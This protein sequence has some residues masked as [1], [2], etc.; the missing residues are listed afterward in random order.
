MKTTSNKKMIAFFGVFLVV[1]FTFGFIASNSVQTN[2]QT[3][4][5][6]T[7]VIDAGHGGP[8]GGSVGKNGTIES[9]LNL[10]YAKTLANYLTGFGIDVIQTRN[11]EN[12]LTDPNADNF[13]IE[14]MKKRVEIINKCGAQLLVSIHMNKFT[15]SGEN[16]A[17]VF[18]KQDDE[19]SKRLADSIKNILI[20]NFDNARKL[21]LAG[22]YYIL[23]NTSP[24]GVIVECGFLSNEAEEKLLNTD[25][26]MNKMCYSIYAGIINFLG[27]VNF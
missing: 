13:K 8:D 6:I 25:E 9:D 10:K 4:K 26:Y 16:G 14:D 21:T 19:D 20:T 23:N 1:I 11:D 12:C 17:Q 18:F 2:I 22:D 27:V 7:I 3:T 15:Q 5:G 24:I